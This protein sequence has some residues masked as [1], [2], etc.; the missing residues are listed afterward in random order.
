[1]MVLSKQEPFMMRVL[2]VDDHGMVR[3]GLRQLLQTTNDIEVIG[4]A[5]DG[6]EAMRFCAEHVPDV[7]LMDIMMP[8]MDGIAAT[9][10]IL[11][12]HSTIKVV[13]FSAHSDAET[14]QAAQDAGA[15][16]FLTKDVSPDEILNTVRAVFGTGSENINDS[17]TSFTK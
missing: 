12:L 9:R 1:M 8:E 4:L 7:V 2:I 5:A 15:R 13:L 16:G 17:A 11:Q 14:L 10:F 3:Q 6:R